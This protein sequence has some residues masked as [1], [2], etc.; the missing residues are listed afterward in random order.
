MVKD[1]S[2]G[3]TLTHYQQLDGA[4]GRW[5]IRRIELTP[6]EMAAVGQCFPELDVWM[7]LEDA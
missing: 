3:S 2:S 5:R 6:G 7:T 1:V 4:I